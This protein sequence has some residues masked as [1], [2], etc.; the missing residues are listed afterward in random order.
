[1]SI[2]TLLVD[3]HLLVMLGIRRLLE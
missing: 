2:R 3:D 1:M